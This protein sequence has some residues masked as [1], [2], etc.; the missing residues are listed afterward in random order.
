MTTYSISTIDPSIE[1]S[2]DAIFYYS[3]VVS[4]PELSFV[5]PSVAQGS[6]FDSWTDKAASE[7]EDVTNSVT[8]STIS[9]Q[10]QINYLWTSGAEQ[11][12]LTLYQ[13]QVIVIHT[14]DGQY[15]L[16]QIQ[17]IDGS[18]ASACLLYTS[19]CV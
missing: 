14:H 12:R 17:T 18:D 3:S 5:S 2:I 7:F 16:V 6:P 13:G 11:T 4:P 1:A 19:R 10:E 8:Y 9:T 15:K